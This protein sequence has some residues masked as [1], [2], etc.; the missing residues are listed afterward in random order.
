[1]NLLRSLRA[2]EP[3][4]L[5]LYGV[6]LAV[7]LVLIGYGLLDGAKAALWSGLLVAVLGVPAV[8]GARRQVSPSPTSGRP[9]G[10]R[11]VDE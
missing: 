3:V 8:E 5:Y 9:V 7:L 6:G 11:H 10:G 4:R 1:M 2:S